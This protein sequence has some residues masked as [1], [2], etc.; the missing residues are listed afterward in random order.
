MSKTRI[1]SS[2]T[3]AQAPYRELYDVKNDL[4]D[5]TNL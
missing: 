1:G 3:T 4:E 5:L 2:S